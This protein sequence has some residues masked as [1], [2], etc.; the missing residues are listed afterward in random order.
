MFASR[1]MLWRDR[2]PTAAAHAHIEQR[3]SAES[4]E[5]YAELLHQRRADAEQGGGK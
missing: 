1:S 5:A 4:P 2:F 3:R